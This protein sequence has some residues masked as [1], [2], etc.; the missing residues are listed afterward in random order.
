MTLVEVLEGAAADLPDV[1]RDASSGDTTWARSGRPF[2]VLAE[3]GSSAEFEL[4]VNVAAAAVR[5]PDTTPSNR[6]SGWVRFSPRDLDPHA[7][8]RATAWFISAHR[9]LGPR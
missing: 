4:D 7:V 9:R 1:A 5:T 3:D 8:D 2:A 6:G